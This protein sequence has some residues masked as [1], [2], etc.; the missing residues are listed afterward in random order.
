[1]IEDKLGHIVKG[2]SLWRCGIAS[3]IHFCL[4][5][6]LFKPCC[7]NHVVLRRRGRQGGGEGRGQEE[8]G[9]QRG[10]E[11]GEDK[12]RRRRRRRRREGR[13]ERRKKITADSKEGSKNNW[14]VLGIQKQ[15]IQSIQSIFCAKHC[16]EASSHWILT[17]T[18]WDRNHY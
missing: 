15:L 11:G 6:C 12:R 17:N 18:L 13:G 10:V 5:I 14:R 3:K 7:V 8:E 2:S 4:L 1:M 9:G 16:L